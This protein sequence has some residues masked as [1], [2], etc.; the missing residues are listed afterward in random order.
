MRFKLFIFPVLLAIGIPALAND[1]I[2]TKR[3]H[4]VGMSATEG[5]SIPSKKLPQPDWNEP[6]R[7][8]SL[9]LK[10]GFAAREESW[11]HAYYNAPYWGIGASAFNLWHDNTLG[12]PFSVF[13]FQGA[14]L[15]NLSPSLSL[16][17]ELQL[18]AS[19]NWKHYGAYTNPKNIALGSAVNVQAGGMIYLK[20]RLS[21]MFDL[22]TGL[23]VAHF[24]NGSMAQPNDGIN[25]VSAYA[26][27]AYNINRNEQM[28]AASAKT[29]P[30]KF[31]K[32]G[33][34]DLSLLV[35]ARSV[36]VDTVDTGLTNGY[37]NR[38]FK[39]A[40]LSYSYRICPTR[41]FSWG[42][43][44]EAVYDESSNITVRG[45]KDPLTGRYTREIQTGKVADRFSLGLSVKGE[46]NM[47]GYSIF[48]HLGYDV[49][50]NHKKESRFYQIYGVKLYFCRNTFATFGV[51]STDGSRSQYLYLNIGYTIR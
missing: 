2:K 27:I 12:R 21:D 44:V 35:S 14:R 45:Y 16:N 42:P 8:S 47:P 41:L 24:S 28:K 33:E 48:T 34:H 26:G 9:T 1:S 29:S 40:G 31:G 51:R 30:P 46:L 19:F 10:Y 6:V 37:I 17:Y 11:Q 32:H 23:N 7:H 36:R 5:F 49:I 18:G 25:L 15:A 13:L 39:V 20:W 4:I 22:Q 50:H 3:A 38:K 43:S